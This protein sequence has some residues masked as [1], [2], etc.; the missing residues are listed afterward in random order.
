[1]H[2]IY[3]LL[4]RGTKT[5]FFQPSNNCMITYNKHLLALFLGTFN[6]YQSKIGKREREVEEGIEKV[7]KDKFKEEE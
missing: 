2:F 5:D 3:Y 1:M 6:S 7:R 4:F